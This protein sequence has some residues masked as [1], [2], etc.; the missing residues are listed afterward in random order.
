[1]RRSGSVF[2][3]TDFSAEQHAFL[4]AFAERE[5]RSMSSLVRRIVA[6]WIERQMLAAQT[7]HGSKPAMPT[8]MSLPPAG[9][10]TGS[11]SPTKFATEER[12]NAQQVH[13]LP[14]PPPAAFDWVP[15]NPCV[16]EL[17]DLTKPAANEASDAVDKPGEDHR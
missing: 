2:V 14:P 8:V 6:E 7:V 1:M 13:V 3:G 4:K 17:P 12:H 9:V 11:L 10:V 16:E 15:E 5:D